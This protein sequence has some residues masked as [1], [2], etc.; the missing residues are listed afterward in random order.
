MR[1][2]DAV[3]DGSALMRLMRAAPR[4]VAGEVLLEGDDRGLALGDG[5][6][7]AQRVGVGE[8][9][10]LVAG[11]AAGAVLEAGQQFRRPDEHGTR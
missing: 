6:E 2:S 3:S 1:I 9:Q 4:G 7:R 10:Q 11:V 5:L 8:L